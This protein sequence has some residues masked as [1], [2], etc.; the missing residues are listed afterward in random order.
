MP[1]LGDITKAL[2]LPF[3]GDPELSLVRLAPL[4]SAKEGALSFVAQKKFVK[5]LSGSLASAVICP[6][7]WAADF[8]GAIIYS[9]NPYADFARATY[10]FDNR[11]VRTLGIHDTAVVAPSATLGANLTIG[12]GAV[13][14]EGAVIGDN[15][16][17]GPNA[18][19]GAGAQ[20]GRD[21]E[22]RAGVCVYHGVSLGHSCLV[23]A[24]TVIGSD[25]FG[26]A[27]TE[28]GW[29]KILQLGSVQI[30]DRVE[31][32]AGCAIDRGALTIRSS[33]VT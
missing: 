30:G 29:Q 32:G 2:D 22:L 27:P 8:L 3:K 17:I 21:S 24:N 12:A 16:W 15:A 9:D 5:Q 7:G 23:H 13:I 28:Q 20:V 6:Q 11:P 25:G 19:V 33:R 10:I 14:D 31:I 18:W 26:F 1:T 4:D